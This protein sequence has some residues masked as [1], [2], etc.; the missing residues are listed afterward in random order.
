MSKST[1]CTIAFV[2]LFVALI[3]GGL[4]FATGFLTHTVL[5]A[6][7]TGST[8]VAVVEVKATEAPTEALEAPVVTEEEAP[9]EPTPEPTAV[10][11]IEIPPPSGEA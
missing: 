6:A 1:G 8:G 9:P 2:V 5:V 4:G 10:P 3:T 7:D 11:T